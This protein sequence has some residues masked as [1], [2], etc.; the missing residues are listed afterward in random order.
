M[1]RVATDAEDRLVA[2]P[3]TEGLEPGVDKPLGL[4]TNGG[5]A[6]GAHAVERGLAVVEDVAA[7]GRD[8]LDPRLS[9]ADVIYPL[10]RLQILAN[11][12]G[13]ALD[14][15]L[16]EFGI[17]DAALGVPIVEKALGVEVGD[18]GVV[19]VQARD[20]HAA[21]LGAGGVG[22][23]RSPAVEGG[24]ADLTPVQGHQDDRLADARKHETPREEWVDDLSGRGNAAAHQGVAERRGDVRR[25]G[26]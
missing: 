13:H 1:S 16:V 6:G 10:I 20:K 19:L 26:R 24:V 11:R 8:L 2:V 15:A 5:V 3:E 14:G 17:A 9:N 4:V 7:V 18:G 22:Q 25:E 21:G 12:I 23:G